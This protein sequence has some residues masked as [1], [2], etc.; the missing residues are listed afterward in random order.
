M[1]VDNLGKTIAHSHVGKSSSVLS[2]SGAAGG[3]CYMQSSAPVQTGFEWRVGIAIG[4]LVAVVI[5]SV[6][7][8]WWQ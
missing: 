5:V 2:R 6:V 7:W 3:M 1:G 8:W 4:I